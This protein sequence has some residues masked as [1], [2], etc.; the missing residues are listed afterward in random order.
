MSAISRYQPLI[1]FVIDQLSD[2][3]S[4]SEIKKGILVFEL[5]EILL[6]LA[7]TIWRSSILDANL[8]VCCLSVVILA[9]T[10]VNI[11]PNLDILCLVDHQSPSQL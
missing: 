3:S 2:Q 7:T 6:S 8:Q 10:K 11:I 5:P 4:K 1:I 9:L